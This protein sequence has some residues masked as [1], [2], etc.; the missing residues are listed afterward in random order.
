MIKYGQR[1]ISFTIELFNGKQFEPVFKGTTIGR[2][3]IARFAGME[4]DR[5]RITIREA[6]AA[7][8]LREIAAYYIP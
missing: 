1:V 4:T 7:P 6:K 3:K 8:V 2:K 5:I